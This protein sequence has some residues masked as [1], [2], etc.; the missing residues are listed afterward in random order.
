LPSLIVKVTS[1]LPLSDKEQ[2][3]YFPNLYSQILKVKFQQ[4]FVSFRVNLF[5]RRVSGGTE[6]KKSSINPLRK[7]GSGGKKR[8]EK[9]VQY[10]IEKNGRKS[11]FIR[12]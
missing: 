11:K 6:I 1:L 5:C 3:P 12:T 8:G 10:D 2:W 9:R 4:N 7:I